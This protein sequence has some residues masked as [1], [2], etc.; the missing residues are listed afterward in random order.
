[1]NIQIAVMKENE[2]GSAEVELEMDKE[3]KE[4]FIREG[5][6]YLIRQFLKEKKPK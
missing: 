1:M 3:A 4:L 2:D 5:F 6:L